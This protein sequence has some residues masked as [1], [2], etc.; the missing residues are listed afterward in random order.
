MAATRITHPAALWGIFGF[1]LILSQAVFRLAPL[2]W[3]PIADGNLE[4][5]HWALYA[6]SVVFNGYCEGYRAFQLQVA[7]RVVARANHLANHPK[8][9]HVILA[10]LFCMALFHASRKRLIVSWLVYAGIVAIV[11]AVRQLSLPWRG[12]V[13]AGVVVGLSWGIIAI[14]ATFASVARGGKLT[15]SVELPE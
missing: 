3:Q 4:V 13:D 1:I 14:L 11:L 10:P 9:L 15:S 12:I 6:A 8:P 7:P 2:A 5:W